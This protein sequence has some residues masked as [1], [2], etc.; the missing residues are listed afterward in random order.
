M[1]S[2]VL[3]LTFLLLGLAPAA[4]QT[5]TPAHPPAK[6]GTILPGVAP[7]PAADAPAA[8]P[9]PAII[10]GSPLAALASAT[11][12]HTATP[13]AP[14]PDENTPAP[15]GTNEIG[16][17][18]STAVGGD[19]VH[20]VQQ[21]SGAVRA[22]TR[23]TPVTDWLTKM[24]LSTRHIAEVNA[25]V[26]ALLIAVLPAALADGIVR[27]LLRRPALR[28]ANWAMPRQEEFVSAAPQ[29]APDREAPADEE[30]PAAPAV[31]ARRHLTLRAW[32]RRLG[33]ALLKLLLAMVPVAAFIVTMLV[34]LASGAVTVRAAKLAATG[35]GNAYLT[36][37][38]V[39]EL[40]RF[41]L[42]P[43]APSLRLIS[44]P[45]SRAQALMQWL[46]VVLATI[47][48]AASLISAALVLGI[49][50]A[51]AAALTRIAALA[52][53]LEAAIGI[54]QCRH[55]VGG[56]I[57]GSP[58]A[59]GGF[60]WLRRRFGRWWHYVALFY[61]MALWVAWTAGVQNAFILMLRSI[62]VLIAGI[63]AGGMAWKGSHAL[64]ERLLAV[65]ASDGSSRYAA[66]MLR[67]RLY[68]P[69]FNVFLR[70]VIAA[71]VVLLVLEG[72]G[73]DALGWLHKNPVS[74][75][76]ISALT[77]LLTTSVIA[78]C[79][80]EAVNLMLQ[81]RI[82]RLSGTG[83]K[84]QASRLRTLAPILRG[85]IG[86]V[87]FAIAFVVCLSQ[88][89]VN[90]TGLLA[91]SSIAGI[92][93]GFGSQ[94][95]VQDII[96]GLFMLLEDA[97]QVGDVV[98]LAG[99]S[100]TVEKLSIR[101]IHL[102]GGD[103]SINIIPF[104]SVTTVTNATRDFSNAEIA[105]TVGYGEDVDHVCAILT[106]I[107]RDMRAETVWGAMI[108]DDLQIFGLDKFSERGLIISAQFRTGPGQ[109]YAV[110]REFY[111]RVQQRFN[112]DGIDFP[113]QQTV[114]RLEMPASPEPAAPAPNT[115]EP[116]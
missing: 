67:A 31:P 2:P 49:P 19:A 102:R 3:L 10:P 32:G 35:I 106:D 7:K 38:L 66:L 64:L 101:T 36:C 87:I 74:Q 6:T 62:L 108:R 15:F 55:L 81:S 53:H 4:A 79:L 34:I 39:Q 99:M 84:R 24:R 44:M 18:V 98:T 43:T 93:V 70:A 51:G 29:T 22:A 12:A 16:F 59:K 88:I 114:F 9:A 104:S 113:T 83:R 90:T 110:R 105:V 78:L 95:L 82:E 60:P 33:F 5:Q 115:P 96:T 112:A 116:R 28:L 72:W 80:W 17:V 45:S 20:A 41:L 91:V 27:A 61:V 63:T 50:H 37:R 58:D 109:H 71:A 47:F 11:G 73:L 30:A 8:T 111:R 52:V 85:A 107:G 14:A 92:A 86:T 77:S 65:P 46:L 21:F 97:I 25:I 57:A 75:A 56:W 23:L 94:K 40:F 69:A 89:G 100:G 76:L 48:F 54:W 68:G 1:R 13:D 103:G 26:K 42:S